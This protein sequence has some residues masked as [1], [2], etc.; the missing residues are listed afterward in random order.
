MILKSL[1][2][3]DTYLTSDN[4]QPTTCPKCSGRTEFEEISD[5]KQQHKCLS[6]EYEF[7]QD[8][9]DEFFQNFEE[10]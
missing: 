7:F 2:E 6:C 4:D 10:D 8:F 3:L 5:D 1:H 9:E